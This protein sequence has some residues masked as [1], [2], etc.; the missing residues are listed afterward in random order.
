MPSFGRSA[1]GFAVAAVAAALFAWLPAAAVAGEDA[2]GPGSPPWSYAGTGG[3]AF[4]GALAPA[5]AACSTG[6]SQSPIDI[7]AARRADAP[8]PVFDY[9]PSP[10]RIVNTGHT[11][12]VNYA[13]GS[14]LVL[15]GEVYALVQFHFHAPAEHALAGV[16]AAMEA[17]FVHR[18]ASGALAVVGAPMRVGRR[19]EALAAVFDNMPSAPGPAVRVSGATVDASMV[20]PRAG[21]YFRY[22]GSLTTPPC[23]EG[24]RWLVLAGAI[25]ASG[26]QVAAFR[27]VTGPNARPL[28]ALNG[29]LPIAPR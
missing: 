21:A 1:A 27:R 25:E 17:H 23:S 19:N 10:L 7:S 20:L 12:Q 13:P 11:V 24:V 3:P 8:A 5:W 28:Q 6:R 14:R 15:A 16:R 26:D 4:W 18:S 2:R 22:E 9:R 29:R